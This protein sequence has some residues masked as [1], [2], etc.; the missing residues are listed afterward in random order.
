MW[1]ASW[2][3]EYNPASANHRH[4]DVLRIFERCVKP[5]VPLDWTASL[6]CY[7]LT[8]ENVR[9]F[10]QC[11]ADEYNVRVTLDMVYECPTLHELIDLVV[12]APRVL[13]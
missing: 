2:P 8:A 3:P 9:A 4:A 6:K 1:Q 7:R 11:V 10:V 5:R 12:R 13:R